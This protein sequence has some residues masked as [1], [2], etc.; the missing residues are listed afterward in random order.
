MQTHMCTHTRTH[1]QP[2]WRVIEEDTWCQPVPPQC[3]C[4]CTHMLF[5][6]MVCATHKYHGLQTVKGLGGTTA[7]HWGHCCLG[8]FWDKRVSE[9]ILG[10]ASWEGKVLWPSG[11]T[12]SLEKWGE[13]TLFFPES[14]F[15]RIIFNS[16]C[17]LPAPVSFLGY[18]RSQG[19]LI[20]VGGT[21]W[22][23]LIIFSH[24]PLPFPFCVKTL[25][26]LGS[27]QG[28]GTSPVEG[29]MG[30]KVVVDG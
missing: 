23:A 9:N 8:G 21:L 15:G 3:T 14:D 1:T 10:P 12:C 17:Y 27:F 7:Y 6:C 13:A 2:E 28:R 29:E 25:G 4:V 26:S 22:V 11:S 19:E 24:L 20:N 18:S 5:L 30:R 16:K